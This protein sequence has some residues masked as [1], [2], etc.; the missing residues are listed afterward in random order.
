MNIIVISTIHH[1]YRPWCFVRSSSSARRGQ[2]D[3]VSLNDGGSSEDDITRMLI[4]VVLVFVICQT[5]ALITQLLIVLLSQDAKACPSPF[6]FYERISDLLVV[7]NSSVNFIIY[8]FCSGTFRQIV[9]TVFCRRAA[10]VPPSFA[11]QRTSLARASFAGHG[12][13]GVLAGSRQLPTTNR[14]ES[15]AGASYITMQP[16]VKG[17]MVW[18]ISRGHS[19]AHPLSTNYRS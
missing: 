10:P 11:A 13:G 19:S 15:I 2:Q 4:V 3:G 12:G 16:I 5:P 1:P 7:V 17:S 18:R 9:L 6:F 8:C 14:H